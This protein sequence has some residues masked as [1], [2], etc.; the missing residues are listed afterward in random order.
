MYFTSGK[1][2]YCGPI[3]ATALT[4]WDTVQGDHTAIWHLV[5][6]DNT[7][8]IVYVY[9]HVEVHKGAAVLIEV[10]KE[11]MKAAEKDGRLRNGAAFGIMQAGLKMGFFEYCGSLVPLG[12]GV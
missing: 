4:A 5:S 6:E 2:V 11:E 10:L 9:A 3:P 1:T 7:I 12:H 8:K